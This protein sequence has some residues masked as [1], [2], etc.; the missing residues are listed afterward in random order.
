VV[1]TEYSLLW[2]LYCWVGREMHVVG[3]G[4][5][6]VCGSAELYATSRLSGLLDHLRTSAWYTSTT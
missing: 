1:T 6:Y 2:N 4:Y 5:T 3:A